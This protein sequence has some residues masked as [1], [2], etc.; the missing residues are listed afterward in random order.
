M[1][2]TPLK[3]KPANRKLGRFRKPLRAA[4]K[5]RAKRNREAAAKRRDWVTEASCC[6]ICG[7]R[8]NL[9]CHEFAQ[10]NRVECYDNPAVILVL[11][12]TAFGKEGCHQFVHAHG[13]IWGFVRCLALLQLRRPQHYNLAEACRLKGWKVEQSDVDYAVDLLKV[14]RVDERDIA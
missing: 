8:Q 7:T 5:K 1:K 12:N 10:G 14:R 13:A 9:C 11:C 2:R 3:R 6:D 4:S